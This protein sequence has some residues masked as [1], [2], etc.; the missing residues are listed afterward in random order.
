MA[1]VFEGMSSCCLCEKKLKEN[2]ELVL[3]PAFMEDSSHELWSFTDTGYH[4]DCFINWER[5]SE[6]ISEFNKYYERHY[7]G[8]RV[9]DEEGT[10]SDV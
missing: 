5:K 8:M 1:I 10:I 7:R 6:L 2:D 3:I 9:M 4:K